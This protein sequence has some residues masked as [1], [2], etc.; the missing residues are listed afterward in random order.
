MSND[1]SIIAIE[2]LELE[3]VTGGMIPIS[4]GQTGMEIPGG[5][6]LSCPA[7]TAPNHTKVGVDVHGSFT[8]EGG[9]FH[10]NL[11]GKANIQQDG[12]VPVPTKP[13]K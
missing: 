2:S 4:P 6:S 13:K 9:L 3:S 7:G 11:G 10:L 5:G 12:C 8:G 1:S